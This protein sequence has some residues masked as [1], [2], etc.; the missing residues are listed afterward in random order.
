MHLF[1]CKMLEE[2]AAQLL[3]PCW[4]VQMSDQQSKTQIYSVKC[5]IRK[6]KAAGPPF[7]NCTQQM[8][9]GKATITVL[10]GL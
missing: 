3:V 4:C 2:I 8:W 9:F 1:V 5:Y 6:R 10:S 7:R